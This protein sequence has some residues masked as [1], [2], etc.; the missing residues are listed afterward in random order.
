MCR[1]TQGFRT[2]RCSGGGR[3]WANSVRSDASLLVLFKQQY[4]FRTC[5]LRGFTSCALCRVVLP[6]NMLRMLSLA[7]LRMQPTQTGFDPEILNYNLAVKFW[8]VLR[9]PD[10]NRLLSVHSSFHAIRR[11]HKTH[12]RTANQSKKDRTKRKQKKVEVTSCHACHGF[13]RYHHRFKSRN[14]LTHLYLRPAF[15]CR[16]FSPCACCMCFKRRNITISTLHIYDLV[17]H[18]RAS[19][20]WCLRCEM[21]LQISCFLQLS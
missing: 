16:R 13:G 6:K 7:F 15:V 19:A 17:M 5:H 10:R 14:S 20:S 8:R 18:S 12:T 3:R 2:S 1:C 4:C 11:V 9:N 21:L